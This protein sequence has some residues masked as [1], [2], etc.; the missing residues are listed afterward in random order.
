[1]KRT[2]PILALSL[3]L[4]ACSTSPG[5]ERAPGASFY[6]R[7]EIAIETADALAVQGPF[8]VMAFGNSEAPKVTLRGPPEMVADTLV[9]VEDGTLSI[10]FIEGAEW[11]WNTGA[12]M[13]AFV[14][15]PAL[16]SVAL[17]GSGSVDVYSAKAENFEAGTGG[18]GSITIHKLEA[19]NVQLGVGGSGSVTAGGTA[20]NAIYGVG[21]SGGVN[22]K[23][24]RVAT[25]E[26]GVGGSGSIYADVSDTAKIGVG[27]SGRV[28]VVGGA[29]CTFDPSQASK[30]ECR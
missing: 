24:L 15:L 30:I 18:S 2:L 8:K 20:T 19:E 25:A 16:N 7:K 6:E 4:A 27:G 29:K 11:Q 5:V 1:M 23:G 3:G 26:I 9:T 28:D 21:G 14:S 22:A 10:R 12:G 17:Q 13:H